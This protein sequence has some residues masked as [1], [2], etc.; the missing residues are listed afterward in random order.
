LLR[1][2]RLLA[3]TVEFKNASFPAAK[4]RGIE[5]SKCPS[6]YPSPKERRNAHILLPSKNDLKEAGGERMTV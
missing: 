2:L 1:R 4:A 6:S 3:K 5:S